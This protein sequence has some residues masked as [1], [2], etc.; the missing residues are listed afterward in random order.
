MKEY[1][2][3]QIIKFKILA[4]ARGNGRFNMKAYIMTKLKE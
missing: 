3:L 4:S 1:L 2:K